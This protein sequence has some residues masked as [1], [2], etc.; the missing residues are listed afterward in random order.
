V[1]PLLPPELPLLLPPIDP[2][3]EV[4]FPLLEAP[5]LLLPPEG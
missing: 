2:P 1:P 5:L 3:P 4:L